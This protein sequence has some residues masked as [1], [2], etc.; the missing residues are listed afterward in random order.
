MEHKSSKEKILESLRNHNHIKWEFPD[1]LPLPG[2]GYFPYPEPL[3]ETF[4]KELTLIGG[5]VFRVSGVLDIV[6]TLN[7]LTCQYGWTNMHCPNAELAE[8]LKDNGFIF[9]ENEH[10]DVSITRCE[11]LISRSGSV[12]V[13]SITGP[14][15]KVHVAPRTHLVIADCSQLMPFFGDAMTQMKNKY[16]VLP[17]WVGL[18]TG[19]SRTADIEK[20]LVMG[21]HGPEKLVVILNEGN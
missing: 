1:E 2:D 16:D 9:A 21:A 14:G 11:Y 15:R 4:E 3:L 7:D 12:L 17:S 13:S 5:E 10:S 20:T 19:P 6:K 18:I 8:L